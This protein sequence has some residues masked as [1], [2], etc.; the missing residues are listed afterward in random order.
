MPLGIFDI[1]IREVDLVDDGNELQTLLLGEMDI[2]HG[3]GLDALGGVDNQKSTFAGGQRAG[4]FV[5]KVHMPRSVGEVQFVML[6]ALGSILHGNRVGLDRNASF[7]LEVHRIEELL[8]GLALLDRSR[9][10]QKAVGESRFTVVD[11]GDDAKVA[12]VFYS[13]E[14][15]GTIGQT[16]RRVNL[17]LR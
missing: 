13:H 5:G 16:G 3:L 15:A 4:H 11:V 8:L 10:L 12:R 7:A 1:S 17:K 9:D 6:S 14:K 2:G